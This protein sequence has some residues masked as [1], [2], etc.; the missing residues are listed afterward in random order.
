MSYLLD[1]NVIS[2]WAKPRPDAGLVAWLSEVD[3]DRT[4]ISVIS[5]AE[6]RHGIERMAPGARRE[7]LEAWLLNELPLRFEGRVLPVDGAI[8]DAWGRVMARGQAAGLSI[9]VMDAFMAATAEVHGLSLVTRNASDFA[10][11][12]QPQ[13]N[14]WTG[15]DI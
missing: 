12:G 4:F 9:S 1:T 14:P 8:A 7:R 13:L 5:L 10:A 2:E 15:T 3:E 6:I 11:L